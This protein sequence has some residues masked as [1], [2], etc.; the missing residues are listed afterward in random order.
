MTFT[1]LRIRQIPAMQAEVQEY[2]HKASGARHIHFAT[3]DAEMVFLVG[4]PTVPETSD[5]RA[6]ILEHLALCGSDRYPVRDPFFSML[7]RSTAHFMNAMTY[8]DKTVYPFAS[9]DRTDFFNLLDVYLDA[10]FFPRLDYLD[11][12]QEGWRLAVEGDKL[13][14]HGVVFNEMKGA[15]ADPVRALDGGIASVLLQGTTYEVE[16]GGD[17]LEIPSLTHA[18]LKEFHSTHYHPSQAVFMTAGSVDPLEVQAVIEQRVLSRLSGR[19]PRMLPQL[20]SAWNAPKSVTLNI[21]TQEHGVQ[22]SWL[23]GEHVDPIAYYHAALLEAGLLSNAAAPLSRAMESAGY[24]RPSALNGFDSGGRQ[25]VFHL[26]MEG[27]TGEQVADARKRIWSALEQTA[28][29]G[30]PQS[31]LQATLRDIRFGQREISSGRTPYLLKRLLNAMPHEMYGGDIMN[32]FDQDE[33]L[34]QLQHKIGDPSF[35]KGLVQALLDSPTRLEA[36][37]VPDAAYF[38]KRTQIEEERLAA[39]QQ[40]MSEAE[41]DRLRAESA[42]L[43][44]HQ[45][46]QVDNDI[47]PRIR[48]QDVEPLPRPLLPLPAVAKG[49]N[50]ADLV[51]VSIPSNGI[52]YARVLFDVSGIDAQEWPWLQLY[53]EVAPELGVADRTYEEADAWRHARVPFFDVNLR[54]DQLQDA[55]KSLRIR[56]DYFAKGLREEHQ[57]IAE[58]L[59]DSIRGARFDEHERLAFLIDSSVQDTR[60]ALADEGDTYARYSAS[61]PFSVLRDFEDRTHGTASLAFYRELHEKSQ[62]ESGLKEICDKLTDLHR[63][64]VAAPATVIAAGVEEDGKRLASLLSLPP[65]P[66]RAPV[67]SPPQ[68]RQAAPARIAL[69]AEAQVNHCFAAWQAP[70]LAHPHAPALSVLAELVTNLVLHQALREEGGAY[71]GQAGYSPN[72]GTFVMMSYRDPRLAATYADFEKA[73]SWIMSAELTQEE[74]EEAVICVIQDLDKP[75]APF[76]EVMRAWEMREQGITEEMRLRYRQGVLNCTADD[77]K[78]AAAEWLLDKPCSRAAFVGNTERDLAG[79]EVVDLA[80]LAG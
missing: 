13:A 43:L 68:P 52:S 45:R 38:Q 63:R 22:F 60:N 46:R 48:P 55:G 41:K 32:A 50:G 40:T 80:E 3:A 39:L 23:L 30:V 6:H 58:V 35:F 47:L 57:A 74:I 1:K 11:F 4:F 12:R 29:E 8:A 66:A 19:A 61:A 54:V 67:S 15:F 64:I 65:A 10:A 24:G 76:A 34:E 31:V 28:R 53:A 72:A 73:I 78:A 75:H 69:Y 14:Y 79:L 20:A 2:E 56:V 25:L 37:V 77:V 21:P 59:S 42:A 26:G 51:A 70:G 5:G 49:P 7:R 62:S 16:S 71:G 36:T 18:A 17:P 33:V 27:L 9:T 44:V